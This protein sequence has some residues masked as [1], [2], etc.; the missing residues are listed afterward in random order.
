MQ[1]LLPLP[2]E[3]L[4]RE[5]IVLTPHLTPHLARCVERVLLRSLI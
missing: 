1:P 4:H 2:R 5:A 3:I